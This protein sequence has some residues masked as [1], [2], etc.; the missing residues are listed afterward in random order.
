MSEW[1]ATIRVVIVDD[2]EPARL[3][4]RQHLT[5]LGNV[6]IVSECTNGFEAIKAAGEHKPDVMLLDVQMPKI[7]G[8]EVLEVIGRDIP[9]IFVTAYD[10]FALRAFEVHAVDYLL[11][12]FTATRLGEALQRVRSRQ[13]AA[14]LPGGQLRAA[15]RKPGMPLDRVIIRDGADV[16]VLVVGKIDYVEAQDDYVSFR[17]GGKSLLKEQTLAD[18][19]SQLDPRR[20][21]RIHRSYLLNIDRLAKVEL[22]AKDSREAI[23]QDGTRLP[24]SRTGYQRLQQLL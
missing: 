13:G 18:L 19:E 12:P 4:L 16:H 2:E 14:A 17:S 6:E 3:A 22:Y 24:V 8:F 20:F 23:L 21:V 5:S 10:E 9:V 15:A 7:D 11:K 1:P